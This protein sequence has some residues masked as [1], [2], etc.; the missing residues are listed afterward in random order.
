MFYAADHSHGTEFANDF[1]H[2]YRFKTKAERDAFVEYRSFSEA[3]NGS[4]KTE[5]VT[6]SEAVRHFHD[7]FRTVGDFHD[8]CDMRDWLDSDGVEFWSEGNYYAG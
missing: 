1:A 2:L 4:V 8:A 6:R 7:A 5:A 3:A